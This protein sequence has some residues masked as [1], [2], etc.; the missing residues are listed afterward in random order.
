[1]FGNEILAILID[2]GSAATIIN[3]NIWKNIKGKRDVLEKVSFSIRSATKH[4]LK[5]LGQKTTSLSLLYRNHK[6]S[7][8]FRT[9]V[10]VVKGLTHKAVLG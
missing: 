5:I 10:I 8:E 6:G 1:M 9:N 4:E 3:E 7:K 2:S